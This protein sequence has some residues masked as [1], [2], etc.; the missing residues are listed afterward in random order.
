MAMGA[1]RENVF[2]NYLKNAELGGTTK[3]PTPFQHERREEERKSLSLFKEE[4]SRPTLGD[5]R[6]GSRRQGSVK[7]RA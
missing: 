4:A 6:K 7:R 2:E 1:E 5:G 3:E